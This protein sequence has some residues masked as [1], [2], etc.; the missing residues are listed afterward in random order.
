MPSVL[1]T[2]VQRTIS[3]LLDEETS[4]GKNNIAVDI[5]RSLADQSTLIL[6]RQIIWDTIDLDPF[7]IFDDNGDCN[8]NNDANTNDDG[9]DD[10]NDD[11]EDDFK[12][13][14]MSRKEVDRLK[15]LMSVVSCS[16]YANNDGYSTI[17]AVVQISKDDKM[18]RVND[19]VRLTFCYE[20][21]PLTTRTET[22]TSAAGLSENGPYDSMNK[23]EDDDLV[24]NDVDTR[25]D[26]DDNSRAGKKLNKW[27]EFEPSDD[28]LELCHHNREPNDG[29]SKR[30]YRAVDNTIDVIPT[31]L[32]EPAPSRTEH[33]RNK[34]RQSHHSKNHHHQNRHPTQITYSIDLARDYGKKER[35]LTIEVMACGDSPSILE[36]VPMDSDG[37]ARI[38]KEPIINTVN[39]NATDGYYCHGDIK[40]VVEG[41]NITCSN[42]GNDNGRAACTMSPNPTKKYK[43]SHDDNSTIQKNDTNDINKN[44]THQERDHFM[45]YVDPEVLIDF[46]SW[47]G[48]IDKDG[49][50][51]EFYD[52]NILLLLMTFPYYENEWDLVGFVIDCVNNDDGEMEENE[53]INDSDNSS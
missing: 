36:A 6:E 21:K 51:L 30:K 34:Q 32:K 42:S 7:Q 27:R 53:E 10:T 48:L 16:R 33:R 12:G 28:S 18:K 19:C 41:E 15:K 22:F 43:I 9:D 1:A 20:R 44:D 37:D 50:E 38:M 45:A 17:D 46:M 11:E 31:T 8:G 39:G 40:K 49:A 29:E 13:N 14:K 47:T 2:Q 35:L 24:D 4:N 25:S 23:D 5:L 3:T 52:M 26:K